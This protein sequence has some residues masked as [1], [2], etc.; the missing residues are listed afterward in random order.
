MLHSQNISVE[1]R[2][3]SVDEVVEAYEN[4]TLEEAFGTGTAAVI[5]PIG[6]FKYGEQKILVNNNEIGLLIRK[7]IVRQV[8]RGIAKWND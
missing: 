7:I 8:N 1:E 2:R 5:S 6:E 3:I 4:G